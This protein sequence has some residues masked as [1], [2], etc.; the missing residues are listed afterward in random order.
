MSSDGRS[1]FEPPP[2][3]EFD[4]VMAYGLMEEEVRSWVETIDDFIG[5]ETR[6]YR[7]QDCYGPQMQET[8]FV[9]IEI[10]YRFSRDDSKLPIVREE[11]LEAIREH[12]DKQGYNI[13]TEDIRG[14]GEFHS[15]EAR[16]PDGINLW[17]SVANISSLKVQSG[18]VRGSLDIEEPYIPPAGGVPPQNDPLRNNPPYEPSAEETSEEAINPFRD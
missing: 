14:D 18:C 2:E 1:G 12:W 15:L 3:R 6:I 10:N 7:T 5:F 11:Y 9:R 4:Q 16:R 17:Y 8:D 13:H